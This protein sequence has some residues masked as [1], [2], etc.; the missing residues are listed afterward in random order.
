MR[1]LPMSS[2]LIR[3]TSATL[4]PGGNV[5]RTIFSFSEIDR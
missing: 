3:A 5:S 2:T 1:W 4:T